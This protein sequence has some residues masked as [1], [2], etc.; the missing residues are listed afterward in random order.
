MIELS[1]YH[2]SSKIIYIITGKKRVCGKRREITDR[3]QLE[4]LVGE[5]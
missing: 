3:T 4:K 2:L 5:I 1:A